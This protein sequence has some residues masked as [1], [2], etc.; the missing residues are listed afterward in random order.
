[1]VFKYFIPTATSNIFIIPPRGC[2]CQS[3]IVIL[4]LDI[5]FKIR[6]FLPCV[7]Q[8]DPLCHQAC[9]GYTCG[10]DITFTFLRNSTIPFANIFYCCYWEG[11]VKF[12]REWFFFRIFIIQPFSSFPST[13]LYLL[14][15]FELTC[16][17]LKEF[18]R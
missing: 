17:T 3:S 10:L 8:P 5:L 4:C 1:V 11:L 7:L 9:Y 6:T 12:R 14:I 18:V 2:Q 16:V 15:R 13:L